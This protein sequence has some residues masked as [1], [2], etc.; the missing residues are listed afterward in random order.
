MHVDGVFLSTYLTLVFR[1]LHFDLRN[2]DSYINALKIAR[3]SLFTQLIENLGVL[4]AP[5]TVLA[6]PLGLW[7]S[8]KRHGF[9]FILKFT[10]NEWYVQALGNFS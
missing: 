10:I 4:R 7:P 5:S 1:L 6:I 3:E 8:A 2:H 9:L